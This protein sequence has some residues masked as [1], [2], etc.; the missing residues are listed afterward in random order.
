MSFFFITSLEV[1]SYYYYL[2]KPG[3]VCANHMPASAAQTDSNSARTL[4]LRVGDL[5]EP[6]LVGC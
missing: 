5:F 2:F 4:A 1:R 3:A 6:P